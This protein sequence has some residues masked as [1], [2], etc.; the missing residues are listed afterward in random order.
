MNDQPIEQPNHTYAPSDHRAWTRLYA[1]QR[2]LW[3]RH[4]LSHHLRGV[5]RLAMPRQTVPDLDHVN[6]RLGTGSRVHVRAVAGYVAP[7]IFF[8]LLAAGWFPATITMRPESA[9]DFSPE[10]DLAHDALGHFPLLTHEPYAE[11]LIALGR[12]AAAID[13]VAGAAT[14]DA[15]QALDRLCW[16]TVEAGLMEE[17]GTVRAYGGSLLSSAGEIVHALESPNVSRAPFRLR[18]V[19]AQPYDYTTFQ[20]HLFIA[21]SFDQLLAAARELDDMIRRRAL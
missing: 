11:Y 13:E 15:S 8:R 20:T 2:R 19:I 18:D 14:S 10:P 9:I 17:H 3:E 7:E 4:A 6:A 1:R 5:A 16:F 12:I 21:A